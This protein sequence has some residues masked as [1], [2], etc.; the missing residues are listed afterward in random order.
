MHGSP[1]VA[2]QCPLYIYRL[3]FLLRT[4]GISLERCRREIPKKGLGNCAAG[5][6]ME[7]NPGE[8]RVRARDMGDGGSLQVKII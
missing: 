3:C 5:Y 7:V 2:V 4:W 1:G 8:G 6:N